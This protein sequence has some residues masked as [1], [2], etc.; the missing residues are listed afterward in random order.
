MKEKMV[1]DITVP[2]DGIINTKATFKDLLTGFINTGRFYD[3][4]GPV[5][6]AVNDANEAVAL[7]TPG[8]VL[9]AV[10]APFARGEHAVEYFWEGLFTQRCRSVASK[11][12]G[13]LDHSRS[14]V[15]IK[16]TATLI[17]A[18]HVLNKANVPVA[19]VADEGNIKG[20]LRVRELYEA[21]AETIT[22]GVSMHVPVGT[23][24]V[25]V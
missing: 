10:E 5:L 1:K 15:S 12:I 22:A 17:E 11:P 14:L 21:L 13:E 4:D 3:E 23:A 2:I 6:I 16:P 18:V 19:V 25:S 24:G 7:F 8:D 9:D 20:V